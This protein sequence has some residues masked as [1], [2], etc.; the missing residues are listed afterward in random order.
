MRGDHLANF[1]S[2]IP[3]GTATLEIS[4]VKGGIEVHRTTLLGDAKIDA[5][6]VAVRWNAPTPRGHIAFQ[7]LMRGGYRL[8]SCLT[9]M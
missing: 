4:S 2:A 8:V 7:R 9:P 3:H 6:P 5:V 1:G